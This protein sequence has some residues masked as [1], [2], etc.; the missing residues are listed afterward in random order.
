MVMAI[1]TYNTEA[2]QHFA[3]TSKKAPR[4]NIKNGK[5][6]KQKKMRSKKTSSMGTEP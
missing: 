6:K 5:K 1:K 4:R 3:N 2:K